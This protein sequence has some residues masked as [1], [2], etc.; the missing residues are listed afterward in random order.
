[1]E[2]QTF[3]VV[4]GLIG[5]LGLAALLLPASRRLNVPFTVLLAAAGCAL[6]A[7]VMALKHTHG[8][9]ILGDFFHALDNLGITSEAVFFIFL[10]ALIFESAM[11]LNVRKLMADIQPIL[12]LAV[13]GLLIS[14]FVVGF[15]VMAV[16]GMG[17]VVCLLLGVIV[18]ATDPVAV[19]AIFKDLG[20][21]KRL[22]VLVEGE[23][24]FND[25][26]AIVLFTILAAV[27]VGSAEA[28]AGSAAVAFIKVFFGGIAVGLVMARGF[29]WLIGRMR[30]MP[31]VEITLTVVMAYMIFI[32]CEHYLHISGVMGVVAAGLTTGSYGRTKISPATWHTL[33]ETWEQLG[34]WANSLI[35]FLVGIMVPAVL[36]D[37]HAN[38]IFSLVILLASA[39]VARAFVLYFVLPLMVK[40]RLAAPVSTAYRT[41]MFWGGLRG[42]VSLALALVILETRGL[43]SETKSFVVVLVTGFVLFTL[44]VNATTMGWLMGLLGLDKLAPVD[45]ALRNRALATSMSHIRA[46]VLEAARDAGIKEKLVHDVARDYERRQ[47]EAEAEIGQTGDLAPEDRTKVGLATLVNL[48]RKLYLKHFA[49]GIISANITR[50]VMGQTETVLDGLKA[51][52]IAGYDEAV[53]KVLGFSWPFHTALFFQRQINW[54]GPLAR[55]LADRLEIL[56]ATESAWRNLADQG[57]QSTAELL[58]ADTADELARIAR[59]R[60]ARTNQAIDGLKLQYPDYSETIETR[61]LERVA[62]RLEGSDYNQMLGNQ[63]ISQEVYDTLEGDMDNRLRKLERQP[64]LDLGLEP[65]KLVAKMPFFADCTAIQVAEIAKLL[66]PRLVVPGELVIHKGEVGDRMYFISTGAVEVEISANEPVRLG[67]GDFFGEIALLKDTPRVADVASIGFCQL[68]ALHSR[69]FRQLLNNHPELRETVE[70][71]AQER[72]D[73]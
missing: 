4:L 40:S 68:L 26:T 19:V 71:V 47:A 63:L 18:S 6:G 44:F 31:L 59:D 66:K 13:I 60:L 43:D 35:F 12:M 10:P 58:G 61:H 28:S 16:S 5:L 8:L 30:Q 39:F 42:A 20:A 3:L 52:G 22:T 15:S 50:A 53:E 2:H 46:G 24:L 32:F 67:S 34:F 17:F 11:H 1:M 37:F 65:E 21:P 62:L 64:P 41:V 33:E 45:I 29:L 48:E 38:Q 55:Q 69:D 54:T 57:A 9:W 7:I 51:G 73:G 14:T 49:D 27:L 23:S 56:L 36:F 70:R 25:A 72:L